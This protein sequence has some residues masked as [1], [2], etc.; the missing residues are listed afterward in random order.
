MPLVRFGE[1]GLHPTASCRISR[2]SASDEIKAPRANICLNPP[3]KF[4]PK[5]RSRFPPK[6]AFKND[7]PG[8]RKV[9]LGSS[10]DK[11]NVPI[12]AKAAGPTS[13]PVEDNWL[14]AIRVGNGHPVAR[15]S[16]PL[17]S[18]SQ[19]NPPHRRLFNRELTRLPLPFRSAWTRQP[20]RPTTRS[21]APTRQRPCHP[22]CSGPSA[23]GLAP[24]DGAARALGME[25]QQ[26]R[27]GVRA[28]WPGTFELGSPATEAGRYDDEGLHRVTISQP[29]YLGRH[30][31]TQEEWTAVRR[32][33]PSRFAACRVNCLVE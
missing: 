12:A 6:S 29:F 18:R 5:P 7:R 31:V 3:E 10:P 1:P 13:A 8:V 26:P 15:L 17:M 11:L 19:L 21:G 27:H 23:A 16:S 2:T 30:E 28:N 25:D 20:I 24:Q 33:N 4:G 14:K 22:S 9:V 32:A